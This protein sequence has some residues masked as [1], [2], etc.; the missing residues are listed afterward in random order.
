M[1]GFLLGGLA[2]LVGDFGADLVI[3]K[4]LEDEPGAC[5]IK[6]NLVEARLLIRFGRSSVG[7]V[8]AVC[9][10][11][12]SEHC[13]NQFSRRDAS[14]PRRALDSL[15]Q[16]RRQPHR[17]WNLRHGIALHFLAA[18]MPYTPMNPQA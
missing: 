12:F 1:M 4:V 8:G 5:E 9:A 2:D 17:V 13:A 16:L 7:P 10:E 18:Y 11:S 14:L 15:K 3:E 6:K